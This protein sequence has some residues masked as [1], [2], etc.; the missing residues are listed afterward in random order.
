MNTCRIYNTV[1]MYVVPFPG[2]LVMWRKYYLGLFFFDR[3]VL[4]I[5]PGLVSTAYVSGK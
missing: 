5:L 4:Y 3:G 2:V 1:R